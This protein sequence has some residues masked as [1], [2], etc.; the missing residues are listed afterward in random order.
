M[1]IKALKQERLK[2]IHNVAAF[3]A[4]LLRAP[5]LP[6]RNSLHPGESTSQLKRKER[7]TCT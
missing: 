1:K 7:P 4:C 6:N 2:D 3:Y 5:M